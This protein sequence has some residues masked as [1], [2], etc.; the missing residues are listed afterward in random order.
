MSK[1]YNNW[2]PFTKSVK[3]KKQPNMHNPLPSLKNIMAGKV[4][5]ELS[6]AEFPEN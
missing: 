4:S 5:K 1:Q 3:K 2:G 6:S